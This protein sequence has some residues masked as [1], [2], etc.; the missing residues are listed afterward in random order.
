MVIRSFPGN[1]P[2]LDPGCGAVVN[3]YFQLA[4]SKHEL[5]IRTCLLYFQVYFLLHLFCTFPLL[6]SRHIFPVLRGNQTHTLPSSEQA[7]AKLTYEGKYSFIIWVSMRCL[8]PL[9]VTAM[10][11]LE[12]WSMETNEPWPSTARGWRWAALKWT[13]PFV[14][15]QSHYIKLENLMFRIIYVICSQ[16]QHIVKLCCSLL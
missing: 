14:R 9:E 6:L 5:T 11:V 16:H 13:Q 8:V 15:R 12:S 7:L 2:R 3:Y 1:C 10:L 4:I